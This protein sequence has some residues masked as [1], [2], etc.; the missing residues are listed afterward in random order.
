[1]PVVEE[2]WR[3][4]SA[5]L[6]QFIRARVA[7]AASAED[8]LQDV[9]LKLQKRLSEFQDLAKIEGWL[10]LVARNAVIDHYRM[11]KPTME[12]P[13]SLSVEFSATEGL[14]IE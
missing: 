8:I 6:G 12:L 7:D 13:E 3:S 1:M 11:Q 5:R 4:F 14:E 10:F 9:F 2:V